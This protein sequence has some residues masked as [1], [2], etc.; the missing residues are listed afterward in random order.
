MLG[1]IAYIVDGQP[2]VLLVPCVAVVLLLARF[3]TE[4]GLRHW[5]QEQE[6]RLT[7]LRRE[8]GVRAD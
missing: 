1:G 5:L 2:L 3:P 4:S 8:A 7:D 6:D